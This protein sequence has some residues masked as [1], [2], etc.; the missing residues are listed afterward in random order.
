M[1]VTSVSKWLRKPVLLVTFAWLLIVLGWLGYHSDGVGGR[2]LT[3]IWG[4][5]PGVFDPH[6][7]SNPIAYEIFRHV[8]EPLFYEDLDGT[9]RGLLAE[10]DVQYGDSGRRVTVRLRPSI[11]FHDGTPLDAAIAKA[12]FERLQHFG[13]SPLMGD[14]RDVTIEQIDNR[15]LMFILP[16]PD[17]EFVRLTLANA[18]AAIVLPSD[19]GEAE[20]GWVTCTGP[21]QFAPYLYRPDQ[22]LTL[23]RYSSYRWPPAYLTNQDSAHIPQM[24]FIFEADRDRRL[25]LLLNDTGCL[26]SLSQEHLNQVGDLSRFRLHEAS[27]GVTYLGFNFLQPRWQD[28]R[29]RQAVAM[30]LDK[31]ALAELGPF[32]VAQTPLSPDAIGYDPHLVEES[33]GYHPEQSRQLLAQTN[34]SA[35]DEVVLLIPESNTYRELAA[36]VTAQLAVVGLEQIRVREV[37]RSEILTQRQDFDLLLFDYAW[38]DYTALAI[39]LGSGPR[40]L[41]NYPDEEIADLVQRARAT[42]DVN[43]RQELILQAQRRVL[44]QAIWQPLLV[45]N[46][47]L[48]VDGQCVRGERR[49]SGG[50]LVF[51][52]AT[53]YFPR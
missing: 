5:D 46:I 27:G 18:Y 12:S 26:L 39:F 20:S 10:D 51:H 2:P 52:D 23:I 8:C 43:A 50:M 9:V 49:V 41:L 36:A 13:V 4:H 40:N 21:Y 34:F 42:E 33:I 25:D 31:S 6:R 45:R 38:A 15:T 17:Y 28:V 32:A 35:S 37:P 30:A 16:E 53:T 7:T 3:M 29:A 14:L 11:V 44:E 48:A 19:N 24:H 47:T 22:S 1:M